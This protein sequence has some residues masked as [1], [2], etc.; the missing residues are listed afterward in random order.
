MSNTLNDDSTI[1]ALDAEIIN[2]R[3]LLKRIPVAKRTLKNWRDNGLPYIRCPN[4]RRVL[5]DWPS[6][7]AYLLRQQNTA[8]K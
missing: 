3:A 8:T 4:S 5:Y 2:E 1:A 6:V 7:R